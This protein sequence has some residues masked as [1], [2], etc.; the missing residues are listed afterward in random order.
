MSEKKLIWYG[1]QQAL[2]I[3][4]SYFFV[5]MAYGMTMEKAGFFWGWSLLTSLTVYTGAFQFVLVTFLSGGASILTIAITALFMNS[6]QFF[7][8]LTFVE[9][10][11]KMGKFYPYMVHTMTD[12]TYAVNC[13]ML[14]RRNAGV[15]KL[16]KDD[17][18][19]RRIMFYVALFSRTSWMIGAVLGGV[20]G[21]LIPAQLEGID[22]CMTALFLT[23]FVDQWKVAKNHFPALAGLIVGI[24]CLLFFGA[25]SFMLPALIL[26]SGLLLIMERKIQKKEIVTEKEV[27]NL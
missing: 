25:N 1:F 12:E 26:V 5:S 19:R 8:G 23:I 16:L 10:F 14:E 15:E 22:F 17:K 3:T 11:K 13:A 20:I 2:P 24:L 21:Q 9:D 4:C 6:R 18:K 7:Y 27:V